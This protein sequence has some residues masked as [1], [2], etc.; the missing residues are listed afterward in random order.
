MNHRR[1]RRADR[2]TDQPAAF[3]ARRTEILAARGVTDEDLLA[4]VRAHEGD[5]ALLAA[6]FDSINARLN[7]VHD[8]SPDGR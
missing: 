5:L 7:R 4:F 3:E 8:E 6:V 2:E 1:L